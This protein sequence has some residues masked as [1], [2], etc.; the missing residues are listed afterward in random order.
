MQKKSSKRLTAA[1]LMEQTREE[2]LRTGYTRQT[3]KFFDR[4]WAELAL[5]KA[6]QS[7]TQEQLPVWQ[8]NQNL[9]RWLKGLGR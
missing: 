3:L 4:T 7:A 2:L 5:E 8:K 1:Q 6:Y 9:L